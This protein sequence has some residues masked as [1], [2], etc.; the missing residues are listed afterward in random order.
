VFQLISW[1][2]QQ[3]AD[4][5]KEQKYLVEKTIQCYFGLFL[6]LCYRFAIHSKIL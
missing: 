6:L 5:P 1:S 4:L 2:A 3:N